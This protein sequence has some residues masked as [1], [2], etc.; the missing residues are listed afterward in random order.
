MQSHDYIGLDG[1]CQSPRN[2]E[3]QV[4]L[5]VLGNRNY[6]Q[7]PQQPGQ[8]QQ[9]YEQPYHQ[10]QQ[11]YQQPPYQ[12]S[13]FQQQVYPPQQEGGVVSPYSQQENDYRRAMGS[14]TDYSRPL[15]S[16]RQ[17]PV[18]Q[19]AHTSSTAVN[20]DDYIPSPAWAP[21]GQH[22][23]NSGFLTESHDAYGSRSSSPSLRHSGHAS[24]ADLAYLKR[25][26]PD[27]SV[28]DSR[29]TTPNIVSTML[30]A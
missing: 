15:A 20:S 26:R 10:Q 14:N 28:M 24:A 12:Q 13:Q 25:I 21:V 11:Q 27:S 2:A 1:S 16:P 29:P 22:R 17:T 3:H 18:Y 5:D 23:A 8:F 30:E 6:Q 7:Q 9:P 19:S 4:E